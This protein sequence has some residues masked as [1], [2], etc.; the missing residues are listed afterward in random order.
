M[1]AFAAMAP[2]E[3]AT[4]TG[5]RGSRTVR[6]PGGAR[7]DEGHALRVVVPEQP[8]VVA[9]SP[10]VEELGV[11]LV[12]CRV[13]GRLWCLDALCSH[14]GGRLA[15]GPLSEGRFAMCPLHLFRFDP[16]TGACQ[17]DL[18]PP[19]WTYAVEEDG[20]DALVTLVPDD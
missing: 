16:E 6:I 13:D 19:A 3:R 15:E 14:E 5:A 8:E 10:F 7:V 12:L 18:G 20:A 4:D 11:V 17:G 9:G 2:D 1:L